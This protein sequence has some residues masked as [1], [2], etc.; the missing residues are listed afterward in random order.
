MGVSGAGK[1]TIGR[2]L[3]KS[4]EYEFCDADELHPQHNVDLMAA[5]QPLNDEDRWPWLDAVGHRLEG[6]RAQDR[7]IVM[8]CSALK[9]SYRDALREHVRD[10]FFVFLDGPMP[11]VH[12]RISD[13]KHEFMPPTLLA[14]QYLSLEPLQGD[15]YGIRVDILQTPEL[16]V[17]SI[18]DALGSAATAPDRRER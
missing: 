1:S 7:G 15:E 16:M 8:A 18:T 13:R 3:A 14:S 5:G 12:R 17:A 10:A 4:L 2:L 11:V 9:R 6:N